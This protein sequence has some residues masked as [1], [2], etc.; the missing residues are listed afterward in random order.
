M[1]S[2][3]EGKGDTPVHALVKRELN[4]NQVDTSKIFEDQNQ[5]IPLVRNRRDLDDTMGEITSGIQNAVKK[6]TDGASDIMKETSEN[7]KNHG[8]TMI[9]KGSELFDK[10]KFN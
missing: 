8:N 5:P 7:L 4:G 6:A 9:E 10:L 1:D 2:S 3:D